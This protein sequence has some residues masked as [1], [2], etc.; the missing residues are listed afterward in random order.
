M[1]FYKLFSKTILPFCD[2]GNFA[3]GEARLNVQNFH[4][5]TP[6]YGT[7][8]SFNV[9]YFSLRQNGFLLTYDTYST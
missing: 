7:L 2:R 4:S 3:A 8:L 6:P 1:I 5:M 9:E